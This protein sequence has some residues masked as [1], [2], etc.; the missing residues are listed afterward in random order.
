MLQIQGIRN[1]KKFPTYNS[2]PVINWLQVKNGLFLKSIF[3]RTHQLPFSGDVLCSSLMS[4]TLTASIS[5][6][7]TQLPLLSR[8]QMNMNKFSPAVSGILNGAGAGPK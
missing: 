4:H 5:K 8:P 3:G 7:L 2:L 1:A 6:P